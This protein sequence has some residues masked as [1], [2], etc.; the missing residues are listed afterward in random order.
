[1]NK[2]LAF[3]LILA[4]LIVGCGRGESLRPNEVQTSQPNPSVVGGGCAVEGINGEYSEL[5][6]IKA[7]A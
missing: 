7:G 3:L 6:N 2:I 5:I 1:M 4:V